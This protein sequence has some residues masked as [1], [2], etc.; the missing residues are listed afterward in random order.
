M[1]IHV[2]GLEQSRWGRDREYVPLL[3]NTI[4]FPLHKQ[5]N[6]KYTKVRLQFTLTTIKAKMASSE[7]EENR[8]RLK[9]EIG[10]SQLKK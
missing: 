5:K 8:T 9:C 10:S 1:M 4:L 3:E 7:L 6:L 2:C